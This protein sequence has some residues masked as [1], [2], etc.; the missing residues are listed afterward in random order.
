MPKLRPLYLVMLLLLLCAV[1]VGAQPELLPPPVADKIPPILRAIDPVRVETQLQAEEQLVKLNDAETLDYLRVYFDRTIAEALAADVRGEWAAA[2]RL[3]AVARALDQAFVRVELQA[4]PVEKI[5]QLLPADLRPLDRPAHLY[6]PDGR[7]FDDPLRRVFP[8]YRFYAA[9][10]APAA[11][12][13]VPAIYAVRRT[14]DGETP[15]VSCLLGTEALKAFFLA[16]APRD[17]S[18][19]EFGRKPKDG[20]YRP[21]AREVL[22][23]W[24]R[25]AQELHQDGYYRFTAPVDFRLQ[26]GKGRGEAGLLWLATSRLEALPDGGN[27]GAITAALPLRAPRYTLADISETVTLQP[28]AR[29]N[30]EV[31]KLLDADPFARSMAEQALLQLG[32]AVCRYLLTERA[33]VPAGVQVA[34]DA[35]WAKIVAPK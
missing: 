28:G 2:F 24:L 11:G 12:S 1:R 32:P 27:R 5:R 10:C 13:P 25:L 18:P 35:L 20:P 30:G 26:Q 17:L 33:K 29:P 31:E 16:Q 34:I 22:A 8:D 4:D 9:R 19:E 14:V 21:A 23:A 15:P 7:L 6:H 3:R